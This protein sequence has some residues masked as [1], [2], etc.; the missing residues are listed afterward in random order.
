M[1]KHIIWVV[2]GKIKS[3]LRD[4]FNDVMQDMVSAAKAEKGTLNYE[5]TLA[6]DN[7]SVH[8]YERYENEVAARAHLVTWQQ[9]SARFMSVVDI[10]RVVVFSDLPADLKASFSGSGTVFMTPIG[11]F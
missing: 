7:E 6:A 5:W 11:G 8:I 10:A 1:N 3:G 2:E 9:S 4:D